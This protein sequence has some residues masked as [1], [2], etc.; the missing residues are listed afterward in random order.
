M[1]EGKKMTTTEA[2]AAQITEAIAAS[3]PEITEAEMFARIEASDRA[4]EALRREGTFVDHHIQSSKIQDALFD[5]LGDS[6]QTEI[7]IN[8]ATA[9][10]LGEAARDGISDEDYTTLTGRWFAAF[11][12][13]K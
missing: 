3:I 9:A 12:D 2:L 7:V 4:E 1:T 6:Y 8:A 11:G 5:T 13:A 10:Y